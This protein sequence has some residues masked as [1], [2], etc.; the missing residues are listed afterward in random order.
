MTTKDELR[1][2][3]DMGSKAQDAARTL[4]AVVSEW[5]ELGKSPAM[6]T[7][8]NLVPYPDLPSLDELAAD[9]RLWGERLAQI[10]DA[11]DRIVND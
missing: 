5:H 2:M 1:R 3:Q 8:I 7:L 11:V 10:A 4:F 9:L 6:E